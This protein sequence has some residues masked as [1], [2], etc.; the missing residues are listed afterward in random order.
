MKPLGLSSG[1]YGIGALDLS[2]AVKRVDAA[3]QS[4]VAATFEG[5]T[6]DAV[7]LSEQAQSALDNSVPSLEE[8][9]IEMRAASYGVD[10]MASTVRAEDDT[11][12]TLLN[13]KA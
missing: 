10:A 4:V 7:D 12:G 1:S 2:R 6:V 13:I 3:G 11:L 9:F 5:R 8:A